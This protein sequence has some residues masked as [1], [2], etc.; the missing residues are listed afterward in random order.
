MDAIDRRIE[1]VAGHVDLENA[2]QEE[3]SMKEDG[4]R[5]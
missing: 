1:D 5:S 2:D 4:S 3:V